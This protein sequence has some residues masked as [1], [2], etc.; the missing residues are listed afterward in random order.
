VITLGH[1][2]SQRNPR[3]RVLQGLRWFFEIGESGRRTVPSCFLCSPHTTSGVTCRLNS[4]LSN[5]L[6]RTEGL[7]YPVIAV[8]EYLAEAG[9]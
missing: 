3:S 6:I 8:V 7:D 2:L 9:S 1:I 4:G 5:K